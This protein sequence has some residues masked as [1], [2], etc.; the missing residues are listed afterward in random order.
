MQSS[1]MHFPNV[2]HFSCEYKNT[3]LI[4]KGL[5]GEVFGVSHAYTVGM[6]FGNAVSEPSSLLI[7]GAILMGGSL[8]LRRIWSTW[9]K[10]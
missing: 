2:M 5:R 3:T 9:A 1:A 6:I 10:A 7:L 8:L 4:L